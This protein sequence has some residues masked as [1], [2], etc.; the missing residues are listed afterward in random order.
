MVFLIL[1][2]LAGLEY[3]LRSIPLPDRSGMG[4]EPVSHAP[5]Q[6]SY[7]SPRHERYTT[8]VLPP[9]P[10]PPPPRRSSSGRGR[11]S[12][13]V[14]DMGSSLSEL[15]RLT[16]VGIPLT[17]S[18]IPVLPHARDVMERARSRGYEVIAHLPMEPEG[19]PS[20]RVEEDALLLSLSDDEL[21]ERLQRLLGRLPGVAGANNHMGSRFTA[22][23]HG[24]EVILGELRERGLFFVDS[25]TTS[26]SVGYRTARQLGMK[27]ARR[28]IFIDNEL[29]E[30]SLRRQLERLAAM[31]RRHG[32][33]IGICHP[34]P[35]TIRVLAAI[36]PLLASQGIE[37]VPVSSLV[38]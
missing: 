21:R 14:D 10:L 15:D 11:V 1:L 4:G 5:L 28:Q 33:A 34:H 22:D 2:I 12:I 30:A 13:I 7:S 29:D 36:L 3:L 6:K 9:E 27:T 17:L 37:F 24:M 26:R 25:V 38:R 19:Y 23:V 20:R 31:A 32:E 16:A 18:V 35:E 8:T